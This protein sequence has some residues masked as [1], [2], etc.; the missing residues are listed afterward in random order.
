MRAPTLDE[1]VLLPEPLALQRHF[2]AKNDRVLR[3]L[4]LFVA[5]MSLGGIAGGLEAGKPFAAIVYVLNLLLNL[6][7]FALRSRDFYVR[8]A[9]QIHLVY[10][11]VEILGLKF[12]STLMGGE[13][14]PIFIMAAFLFLAFRLRVSEH[15]LL[16]GT[17][18]VAAVFPAGWLGLP[19]DAGLSQGDTIAVTVISVLCLIVTLVFSQLDRR[20]FLA[21]WRRESSR[22]RER[23]RMR[24]E[25]E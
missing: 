9:R 4:V 6:G 21:G 20:R 14:I 12:T 16:Y 15:L 11:F 10:L 7:V 2:D 13:S 25:I 23:I 3:W 18:W 1:L 19:A 24:E 5:L 8:S 22:Y 17:F